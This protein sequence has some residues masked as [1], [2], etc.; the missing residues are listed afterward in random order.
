MDVETANEWILLCATAAAN[1]HPELDDWCF[2]LL[3]PGKWY[4]KSHYSPP[5]A[6]ALKTLLGDAWYERITND[7]RTIAF[8]P[9]VFQTWGAYPPA[10]QRLDRNLRF[11]FSS[12]KRVQRLTA[13]G[14]HK[15][16]QLTYD[17][18]FESWFQFLYELAPKPAD[19]AERALLA[20]IW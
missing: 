20:L 10:R 14:W 18:G 7:P 2:G 17:V 1:A 5:R 8:T 3:F 11:W 15:L 9:D 6:R 13:I 4:G 16:L 19:A 12:P